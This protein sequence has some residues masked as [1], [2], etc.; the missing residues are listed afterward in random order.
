MVIGIALGLVFGLVQFYLLLTGVQSVGAGR[1]KIV[2]MIAQFFCP[3]A[4]LLLCA[5]FAREQ[6]LLCALI[7]VVILIA[8][9]LIYFLRFIKNKHK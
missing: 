6:L 3:L 2:P 8:G 7:I 9:A 1:L 5:F 4:A